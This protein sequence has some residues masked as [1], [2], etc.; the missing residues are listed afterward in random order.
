MSGN[1]IAACHNH[2]LK[3]IVYQCLYDSIRELC[4]VRLGYVL[5]IRYKRCCNGGNVNMLEPDMDL[6]RIFAAVIAEALNL[7]HN[8]RWDKEQFMLNDARPIQHNCT[9]LLSTGFCDK[10]IIA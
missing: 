8:Y 7:K 10:I 5:H 3:L 2:L 9:L 6:F 4:Y 1:Y